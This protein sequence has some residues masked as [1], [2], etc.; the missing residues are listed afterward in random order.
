MK[1]LSGCL[2]GLFFVVSASA[3]PLLEGRVRLE[4]GQPVAEAQVQLFDLTDLRQGAIVRAM[5]DGTGYFALPLAVL[6]ERALP[7]RFA[8]GPNYPN[9]FNPSTIIPYQLAASSQVRLEVFNLLGQHL[10]TLVD[11]E[12]PAGFH[13]ATWHAVD[14]AGRAVGAGVYI[15][16][17]TVGVERQTGRMV[18]VDGQAGLSAGGVASVLSGASGGSGS[19]GESAQV[20]GLVVS[21]RGLVPYVDSSFGVES[22]MAPV[23]LV[24][25][26]GQYS[27]GKTT[28]DDSDFFDFFGGTDDEQEEEEAA[29]EEEE[30]ETP[31]TISD[32]PPR[33]LATVG[34]DVTLLSV[35]TLSNTYTGIKATFKWSQISGPEVDLLGADA[36]YAQ[37]TVPAVNKEETLVFLLNAEYDNGIAVSDSIPIRIV[38]KKTEKVLAAL[39]DFLDVDTEDR[40]FTRED[41]VDLLERNSDSLKNFI[42]LTSRNLLN[43]DFD[44]LDWITVDKNRIDYPLGGGTVVEDAVSTM[45]NFADLSRYDKVIP[46]IFPLEQGRPGCEAYLGDETWNTPNGVFELGATWLSG[47]DMSCVRKGRIA[48]EFGHTLGFFHSHQISCRK[49]PTIP[50]STID[51][52]DM[53]DSCFEFLC[54]DEDCSETS[55][56]DSDISAN[57][58]FDM[59][60]GDHQERY[61]DY[62]PVHFHA[63]WQ[64]QAGWLTESQIPIP[65]RS[66]EYW[67]TTLESLTPTA[68]AM[69]LALGPDQLGDPQ[70]Y[71]LETRD[72]FRHG[73]GSDG[74][75]DPCQIDVRLQAT[76]VYGAEYEGKQYI[77]EPENPNTYFFGH[78]G[79]YSY[80][81]E[82]VAYSGK[83]FWDP[84]RGIRVEVLECRSGVVG[85]PVKLDLRFTQLDVQPPVVAV[86][87]A[88]E[89]Q[90][91]TLTNR[92][93]E[94]VVVGNASI[95]GRHPTAFAIGT[96][97]CSGSTLVPKA[98][99]EIAVSHVSTHTGNVNHAVLK[100]PNDDAIAPELTVSLFGGNPEA[101]AKPVAS[102]VLD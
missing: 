29:A 41:I 99:C 7:E 25:S 66:G 95:G 69:R 83:P 15:Y 89:S 4:S 65:D 19:D 97:N 71:W 27:A 6:T 73:A 81:G 21:G 57:A 62:F 60:G 17:M 78:Y 38:P 42:S 91:I 82:S 80:L 54:I 77:S 58:D 2:I 64:A 44:I 47:Y 100:I 63:T 37:F 51:P 90:A 3:E 34:T 18:L 75:F 10:A 28:D 87:G 30:D 11:G 79:V 76:N 22:G 24:V 26:S 35:K 102:H 85:T 59:L 93:T 96:D 8:L 88:G 43:V 39:V 9:P 94:S 70:Y 67:L 49:E 74:S 48:H 55:P 52:T 23:E 16:R 50:S 1:A 33:M 40:P 13:T 5:T 92:G 56:G 68:K 14:G 61:E 46:L 84:Y 20:Y 86:L 98:S 12:R 32:T 72:H 31:V 45:S 101:S 53:N 36:E